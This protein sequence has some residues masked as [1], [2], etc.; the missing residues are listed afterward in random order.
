MKGA[1]QILQGF[2]TATDTQYYKVVE[3]KSEYYGDRF[4]KTSPLNDTV[5]QICLNPGPNYNRGK[6]VC[7]GVYLIGRQTFV[8]NYFLMSVVE[9][10]AKEEFEAQFEMAMKILK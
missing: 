7:I 10:C 9:S 8:S 2:K 3:R 6:N 1:T 5:V 4:F